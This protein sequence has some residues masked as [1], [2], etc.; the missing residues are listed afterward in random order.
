MKNPFMSSDDEVKGDEADR[1]HAG[2][3]ADAGSD[4]ATDD[5]TKDADY[6][7]DPSL[8]AASSDYAQRGTTN[9]YAGQSPGDESGDYASG[10]ESRGMH[11]GS[12]EQWRGA[13]AAPSDGAGRDEAPSLEAEQSATHHSEAYGDVP[14]RSADPGQSSYGG[15]NNEGPSPHDAPQQK[16]SDESGPSDEAVSKP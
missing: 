9:Q 4:K 14:S 11:S 8:L 5:E 15:F 1:E 16:A 3:R 10:R 2:G 7:D 13:A 12:Q 6:R